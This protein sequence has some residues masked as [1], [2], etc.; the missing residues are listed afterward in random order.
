MMLKTVMVHLDA[1]EQTDARLRLAAAVAKDHGARIVGAFAQRGEPEQ[2]GLVFNWPSREYQEASAAARERFGQVAGDAAAGWLDVN[3]GGDD[4]ILRALGNAARCC[5]LVVMG[6]N[7]PGAGRTD[8]SLPEQLAAASGRPVLLTPNRGHWSQ[9]GLRPLIVWDP[10]A[11]SA[12]TVREALHLIR[13][14]AQVTVLSIGLPSAEDSAACGGIGGFLAAHGVNAS[15][16][17]YESLE[18]G[19]WAL[20]LSR[21]EQLGSDLLV[22][23]AHEQIGFPFVQRDV[24][25]EES[26]VPV[27]SAS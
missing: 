13:P 11:E 2:V 4:E 8:E 16:E 23:G 12:R 27:L 24:V 15:V 18:Q 10:S 22:I 3:R 20:I 1:G 25:R 14:D 17:R 19:A 26:P 9:I 6:Q 5:D 7:D 21:L